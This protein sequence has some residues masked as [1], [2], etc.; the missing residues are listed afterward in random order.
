[1][2]PLL[3]QRKPILSE[4]GIAATKEPGYLGFYGMR[5]FPLIAELSAQLIPR[6][7]SVVANVFPT[8]A[9]CALMAPSGHKLHPP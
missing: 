6:D 5:Q 2:N 8:G 3:H 1:M 9:S 4:N 7:S